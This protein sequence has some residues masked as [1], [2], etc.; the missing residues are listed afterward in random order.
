MSRPFSQLRLSDDALFRLFCLPYAG[1]GTAVY[2][3]WRDQMPPGVDVVPL[4]LPGHDGRLDES[5]CHDMPRLVDSLQQDLAEAHALDRPFALLGHSMG[6]WVAFEIARHLRRND[7]PRPE[8]LIASASRPPHV[9]KPG[10][11]LHAKPDDELVA[12]IDKRYGGIPAA[13][14]NHPEALRMLLPVLRADM[15]IIET[16]YYAE[17]PPLDVD[18]LALGGADDTVV[19]MAQLHEWRR[20][21]T[22]EF[23]ARM[24][25]GAHFF[26]F[27]GSTLG[28]GPPARPHSASTPALEYII[29]RLR[30]LPALAAL[31]EQ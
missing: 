18:I 4:S 24:F 1:G 11:P 28:L 12:A 19:S 29:Q 16:Y 3:R 14:R 26:P 17:E 21:T 20:H 25:A 6:A 27:H 23:T 13:I 2:Y 10:A 7:G 30:K 9:P 15:Q 22:G 31:E 5:P 8:L